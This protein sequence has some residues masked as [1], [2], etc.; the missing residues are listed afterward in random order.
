MPSRESENLPTSPC[1]TENQRQHLLTSPCL[2]E[3]QRHNL[4]TSPCLAENQRQHLLTSPCLAE[5]QDS[6]PFPRGFL[7]ISGKLH[8][9]FEHIQDSVLHLRSSYQDM[10]RY[11]TSGMLFGTRT[12]V[13]QELTIVLTHR[14]GQDK[15]NH[16]GE[17]QLHSSKSLSDP[18]HSE[19]RA[20]APP[21]LAM[22]PTRLASHKNRAGRDTSAAM[23]N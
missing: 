7:V 23:P 20:T 6:R 1:L 17:Y 22:A 13:Y 2:A 8:N 4:L 21:Y 11:G 15:E 16:L 19:P 12:K 18:G 9:A 3:N 14:C 5:N 10:Q